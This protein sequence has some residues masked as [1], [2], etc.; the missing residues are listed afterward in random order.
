VE[1]T[2]DTATSSDMH[3]AANETWSGNVQVTAVSVIS[4]AAGGLF[5]AQFWGP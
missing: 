1:A 3:L 5:E 4:S 2:G